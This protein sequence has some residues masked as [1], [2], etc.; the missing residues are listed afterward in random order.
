MKA[1]IL[2]VDDEADLRNMLTA[3]LEDFYDVAQAMKEFIIS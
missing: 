3:V 2:I 1:K